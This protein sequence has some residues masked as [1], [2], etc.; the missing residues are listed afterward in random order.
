MSTSSRADVASAPPVDHDAEART[1][2]SD[3]RRASQR[4]LVDADDQ[5]RE[6]RDVADRL[7]VAARRVTG[8]TS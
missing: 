2:A 8:A 3:A 7:L 4:G 1:E 5:R 6:A